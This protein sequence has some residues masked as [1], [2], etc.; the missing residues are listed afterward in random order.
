[1]IELNIRVQKVPGVLASGVSSMLPVSEQGM[2]NRAM[3]AGAQ[4][5]L[6]ERPLLDF[7]SVG[8]GYLRALDISLLAGRVFE[9]R[10]RDVALLSMSAARQFW[11]ESSP[12]GKKFLLGEDQSPPLKVI[13]I[14]G[15]VHGAGMRAPSNPTTYLPYWKHGPSGSGSHQTTCFPPR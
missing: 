12:I 5:P 1:M 14:L 4:I 11:P 3:P 6:M 9:E 2:N 7:R 15:D 10:D 8:P 13:G